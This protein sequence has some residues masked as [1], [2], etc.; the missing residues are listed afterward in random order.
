MP[1]NEAENVPELRKTLEIAAATILWS[2]CPVCH[3]VY[4]WVLGT[5]PKCEGVLMLAIYIGDYLPV[6]FRKS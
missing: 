1:R 4:P 3:G 6:K 5:C 2:R